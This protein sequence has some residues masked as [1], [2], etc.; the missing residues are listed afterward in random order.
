MRGLLKSTVMGVGLLAAVTVTAN[1]QSVSALPPTSPETAAT[2]TMP[3][4][5][6]DKITPN[7]GNN[8]AWQ[9]QHYTAAPS[10]DDPATHP[11][12]ASPHFGPAPN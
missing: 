11:Y 8:A 5:S 7:P 9:E 4:V 3:P 10:N 12:S 6:S 1:A 2:A